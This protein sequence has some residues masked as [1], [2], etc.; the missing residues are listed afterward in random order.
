MQS[1][2]H[3]YYCRSL[4]NQTCKSSDFFQ[5]SRISIGLNKSRSKGMRSSHGKATKNVKNERSFKKMNEITSQK[6]KMPNAVYRQLN[7][8][9]VLASSTVLLILSDSFGRF[10]CY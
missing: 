3:M 6:F 4:E 10:P 5:V 8:P 7:K 1:D 2:E 9:P